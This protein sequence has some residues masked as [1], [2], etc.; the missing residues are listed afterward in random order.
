M[1]V[2]KVFKDLYI[3]TL[4]MGNGRYKMLKTLWISGRNYVTSFPRKWAEAVK[5]KY[6]NRIEM[7][8]VN[9]RIIITP[10]YDPS[11]KK[12]VKLKL[13]SEDPAELRIKLISYY[14]N[15]YDTVD[16]EIPFLPKE[17]E[18][19]LY[20]KI[21]SVV[22]RSPEG[23]YRITF[24]DVYELSLK[25]NLEELRKLFNA[26]YEKTVDSFNN[27]SNLQVVKENKEFV[28][29]LEN[30]SDR[31]TFQVR[32]YLAKTYQFAELFEK[33]GLKNE[34]DVLYI[35]NIYGYYER[36]A[37]LHKEIHERLEKISKLN[38]PVN[39][40]AFSDYYTHAYK[41][42]DVAINSF[43]QPDRGLEIIR[44]KRSNWEKYQDGIL[45]KLEEE[46]KKSIEEVFNS[47]NIAEKNKIKLVRYLII[48]EGKLRAIPDVASN[49]CELSYN[50][51]VKDYT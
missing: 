47:E 19:M 3:T 13:D 1:K 26:L 41:T 7:I 38:T 2:R 20:E 39:L 8:Q 32:R 10:P 43:D 36:L 33:L 37:D 30:E 46:M 42:I 12:K 49:I 5:S 44:G 29:D 18:Y 6:G 4:I 17:T 21:S 27:I 11:R 23:G 51:N 45:V 9:D 50:R 14:I 22:S 16:L 15:G 35:T 24:P 28:S 34:R 31:I 40:K 48:L 25:K